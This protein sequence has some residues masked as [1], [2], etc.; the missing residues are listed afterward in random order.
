MLNRLTISN[1]ALINNLNLSF[2]SGYSVITGETGAG[3]SILLKALNLLLGERAD[4]SIIR[5]KN[6]KC[7]IEAEFYVAN[8]DLESR[9]IDWDIDYDQYTI[10][11]RE[12]TPS[13][14][15]RLFIN[16]TPTTLNTLKSLGHHLI[17]IHTQ[18]ETLDLF[19]RQFQMDTFDAFVEHN[20]LI[21]QYRLGFYEYQN[22]IK[23]LS[24]LEEKSRSQ[25]KAKGYTQFLIDEFEKADFKN[26]DVDAL[27]EESEQ[28]NNW[29]HI[30]L[31]ISTGLMALSND[32]FG[33]VSSIQKALKHCK[34]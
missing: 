10:I 18:H 21:K 24:D 33:P 2:D 13:G 15:S 23:T 7:V 1:F 20:D 26:L 9:F 3:K 4:L 30:Q 17:K 31:Q 6:E 5:E 12:F 8:L 27:I 32:E 34:K 14:K 25:E 29:E 16:D 19:D 28:L 22:T 11:R